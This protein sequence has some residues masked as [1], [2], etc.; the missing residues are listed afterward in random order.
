MSNGDSAAGGTQET[1]G[2]GKLAQ[3]IATRGGKAAPEAPFVIEHREALIYM[4]CQAAE[5]EHGI[6]C[7]YLFAAFSLKQDV[8]EGLTEAELAAV[9]GWRKQISHVA[10]QEMLHLALVHNLMTAI[11]G[12][13]HLARPNLPLP[14]DHYPA[15]VQLKLLP[16][17]EQAL[18]HFMFLERPEGMDLADAEGMAAMGRA[19]PVMNEGDIVPRLQ[20]FATVGHLYRSIE[21]G[22]RRLAEKYGER[23]LFV[24]P[25]RAQ[26]TQADFGW[27]ELIPV[28]GA[29]S[30]QRAIDEILEQGEG[31]RGEWRDAHFGQ[32]VSIL[33][34]YL[35]MK[36]ANP[37]FDPVR[38]VTAANVR[39]PERDVD[40]PLIGDPLTARVT[41]LFNVAYEV[42][43]LTL[44]RYFAH[45][46]ETD[47]QLK[48]LSEATIAIMLRVL[49]PLGDLITT[50]PVGP[51]QPGRTAGPSF[52]M[53]YESDYLM[54]HRVAAWTLLTE[55]LGAA[56]WL[57]GD[58]CG[59]DSETAH[60]LTPI[61]AAIRDIA[62]TLAAHLPADSPQA[63]EALAAPPLAA[64][65][66][67]ALLTKARELAS[68]AA[69]SGQ[70][71]E[72]AA[73]LAEV[74]G[75]AQAA[76][77]AA[78]APAV[79]GTALPRL[80]DSV[81][82][83]L[84]AALASAP[85]AQP[86]ARAAVGAAG[87][88]AGPAQAAAGSPDAP[89]GHPGA[90][91]PPAGMTAGDLL[92]RA[93][94]AATR[95]RARL[96][97][98][99][100]AP[101]ELVEA[102]AALQDLACALAPEPAHAA[103]LATLWRLQEGLPAEITVA[104][105][106]PYLVTNVRRLVNHLGEPIQG[107]PQVALCRCGESAAKPVCDG[108]CASNGFSGSKDPNRVP[109]RRDAYPG[110]AVTIL[111]NRGL[112]Q[113]S[114]FC[115]DRL[116]T[117]FRTGQE[118]FVAPSGGRLDEIVSAVRECPSGA[119][120]LMIDGREARDLVERG[121]SREP[122]IEVSKDGPYRV[123]GGVRLAGAD[124]RPVPRNQ[125][126]SA[127]HCALCRCGHSQNKPFC[128][129]MHWYI[130]FTDP[131]VDPG[132]EPALF[133]WAGGLTPLNRLTQ[134]LYQVLVPADEVLAPLFAD[135][136]A[137][138]A[139][140]EAAW[141]AEAFGGPAAGE[142]GSGVPAG[143]TDSA[144]SA[145][146]GPASA[147]TDGQPPA[148]PA[149][150]FTVEQRRRWVALASRAADE[151]GLPGDPAFRSALVAY[152]EWA[153]HQ[154]AGL[155]QPG[156]GVPHWDWGAGGP[157]GTSA[158]TADDEQSNQGVPMP[159][160]ADEVSFATHVKPLFRERD[161]QSMSFAFD[162]WSLDDVR[163]H[164]A[165]ILGRLR[166]GSMP[167]DG[168]WPAEQVEVFQRWADSGMQP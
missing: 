133:E 122:A 46:E 103:R 30:A 127:E 102:A 105:D 26:A 130:G 134:R 137:G 104:P 111:D 135:A 138:F 61:L 75:L 151:A 106:G 124:G 159:G 143:R 5:L 11:G 27:P 109:D 140:R 58:L 139:E 65:E 88:G 66:A 25:P 20:D 125:G 132:R 29:A 116:A 101:A 7:Q 118:P 79:A 48:V 91:A 148:A 115:T 69:G 1:A 10:A 2:R 146:D 99:G 67:A 128:S 40:V 82:R 84:A 49:K 33:D 90:G 107:T 163:A 119:L 126:A 59:P 95:L 43:L 98:P 47:A 3:V 56:A 120:S 153:S 72:V 155:S 145:S 92:W 22:V 113:H 86:A 108:V 52:E 15:G 53:F 150:Q 149:R 144:G 156:A 166:D 32:F 28:T 114:G 162:L 78:A 44:E 51:E 141:L 41:D 35:E 77:P 83:P 50:L 147:G 54:P 12:A 94:E 68:Q 57:C 89:G 160:P 4:L 81:L 152:L 80:V 18:R 76:L 129:G 168:A 167:C 39:P 19:V 24:G 73:G 164:A 165:G 123:S 55:R 9:T 110:V 157:P 36:Q 154:R 97:Q 121:G 93:A 87:G 34:E 71:D 23:W 31:P 64:A 136:P 63:R 45:T 131:V 161:Q 14:A 42:L 6:M 8:S 158:E 70:D 100:P 96:G 38:P 74:F 85:A 112:C 16:F 62:R 17:G 142:P 21:A 117:V 60:K 13:P 37:D